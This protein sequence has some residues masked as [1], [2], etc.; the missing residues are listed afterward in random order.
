MAVH[1]CH[2]STWEAEEEEAQGQ[3]GLLESLSQKEKGG[4]KQQPKVLLGHRLV[5]GMPPAPP[6]TNPM[7]LC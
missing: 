3:P 7:A 5:T 1:T 6:L 4:K 2:P